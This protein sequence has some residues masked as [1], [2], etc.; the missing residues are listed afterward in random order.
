MRQLLRRALRRQAAGKA[1]HASLP[2]PPPPTA[3][4]DDGSE[5]AGAGDGD[6]AGAGGA[7]DP[8]VGQKRGRDHVADESLGGGLEA[9]GSGGDGAAA[10]A[11][12][13][14]A[15]TD[16][17]EEAKLP[18]RLHLIVR[19]TSRPRPAALDQP[20]PTS[21]PRPAPLYPCSDLKLASCR[22]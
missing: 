9:A 16:I 13:R 2:P 1:L 14:A 19:V 17:G 10:A 12:A 5:G 11:A 20:P 21:R 7:P 6:G 4:A 18:P 3:A 8:L 22:S 15:K